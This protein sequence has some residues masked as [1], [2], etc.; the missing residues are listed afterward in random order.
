MSIPPVSSALPT[1]PA[2]PAAQVAPPV[3]KDSDGD[4]DGS[5][6][7]VKPSNPGLGK[8]ADHSA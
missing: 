5:T 3:A 2:V 6:G 1:T 8:L 4:H 7:K